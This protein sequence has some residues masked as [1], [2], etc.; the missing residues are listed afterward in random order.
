MNPDQGRVELCFFGGAQVVTGANFLLRDSRPATTTKKPR[1]QI[2]LD[3]GLFQGSRVVDKR[4]YDPFP[5][6]PAE[7][8]AV[9]ISHAHLDHIGRLPRLVREGFSGPVY[10]TPP[11]KEIAQLSLLD[12]LGV[13]E[14]ESRHSQTPLL[15]SE[16]DVTELFSHWR[17][18]EYHEAVTI[19]H[20]QIRL[21]NA[22]HILGSA[23]IELTDQLSQKKIVFTGDLGNSP[24]PL[25]PDT[26]PL[27]GVDYLIMESVYG[28]RNHEAVAT[29]QAKLEDAIEDTMRAGGTLMIPAFSIERTQALLY[30]IEQMMEQSRIPLVPVFLD[31]P[32]ALGVTKLYKK[33]QNYLSSGAQAYGLTGDGLFQF[34]QLHKTPTTEESKAIAKAAARKI[35]L[36]GSGMS[37]GGR[38]LHHE[39]LYLAD[40]R[41]TLLLIGYQS[42][43]SLGR[44][45]QE[46]ARTVKIHGLTVPVRARIAAISG[47]SAHKDSDQLLEF[48]HQ[49]LDGLKQVF[50]VLG[51]PH[52]A[53]FLVQKI[54]DYL[55]VPALNPE[56]GQ[57][58]TLA[59]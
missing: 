53:L 38:I 54:R 34:A 3:C 30:A 15:Y 13:M 26:E 52:S 39:K 59:L 49:A 35:I 40:P 41:S 24:A 14:K 6:Q 5:Y 37:N 12:S 20:W 4:N 43:G 11:T 45:L 32:L 1:T 36:A 58:I 29:R 16:A 31:S 46:G 33:Y 28:D 9:F 27:A 23:M 57:I 22:G 42:P 55:G 50:V 8:D 44:L 51:E 25:L 18:L 7:V 47:Y 19:G 2:M 48:V 17:T 21:L 10:S 56:A